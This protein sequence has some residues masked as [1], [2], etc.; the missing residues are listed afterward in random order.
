MSPCNSSLI[1]SVS[2]ATSP[3]EVPVTS[4]AEISIRTGVYTSIL[5]VSKRL[6]TVYNVMILVR[7]ATSRRS[8]SSLPNNT[9]LLL[10]SKTT[11]EQAV[12]GGAGLS[13]SIFVSLISLL[14]K[15]DS[16]EGGFLSY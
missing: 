14:G 6:S 15:L 2:S 9:S 11:Q 7:L 8:F 1:V 4:A 13:I 5:S 10:R 12:T 16:S 3:A